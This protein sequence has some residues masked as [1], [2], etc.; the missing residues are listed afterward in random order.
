MTTPNA[1]SD[2]WHGVPSNISG[3]RTRKN[4]NTSVSSAETNCGLRSR[5]RNPNERCQQKF[6]LAMRTVPISSESCRL[7]VYELNV[8][9]HW[10]W[11]KGEQAKYLCSFFDT[12]RLFLSPKKRLMADGTNPHRYRLTCPT[13]PDKHRRNR[14][15]KWKQWPPTTMPATK[16]GQRRQNANRNHPK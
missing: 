2:R 16:K 5:R 12:A 4:R 14:G 1:G 6:R 10:T 7:L 3:E 13:A 9:R 11:D 8:P 15:K